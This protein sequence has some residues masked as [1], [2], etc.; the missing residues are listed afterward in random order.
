MCVCCPT[1]LLVANE[2]R[3]KRAFGHVIDIC[4]SIVSIEGLQGAFCGEQVRFKAAKA[5]GFVWNIEDNLCKVPLISGRQTS[6]T[7]G[8]RVY[9]SGKSVSTRCGFTVL[10][11]VMNPL[12]VFLAPMLTKRKKTPSYI[13][14]TG[15]RLWGH[16]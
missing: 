3:G 5:T 7:V 15:G 10:G 4:D 6:L 9:G 8:D 11:E 2:R 1:S 12:G 16:I 13:A 14:R